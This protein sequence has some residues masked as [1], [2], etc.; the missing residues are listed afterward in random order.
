MHPGAAL[1]YKSGGMSGDRKARL[2]LVDD[3]RLM[4]EHL[5]QVVSEVG[6]EALVAPNWSEALRLFREEKP[7]LVLL[8]VIMPTM[9]GFKLTRMIKA[10][11]TSFVPV[12]LLTAL[13][14]VESKRRA[15]A[16]GADDFLSKPVT[17]LEL[18]IRVSSLLRIKQLTDALQEANAK[19]AQL[20]VTDPLTGLQNRRSLYEHL[21]REF[22]RKKR[23]ERPF[24][25][26]LLD[27]D[28]FK[29]V[30]DTHGHQMGDRVLRLVADVLRSQIRAADV[31]GRFGGEEFMILAPETGKD[32]AFA[33]AERIRRT[34]QKAS[35]AAGEG[36][37]TVTI[38][39]GAGCTDGVQAATVE[40]LVRLTDEALYRAKREGRNRTVHA[41]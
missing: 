35:A 1:W 25:L 28:H 19:L 12:I 37:P 7:D 13:E 8:D 29:S 21:D 38:S 6:H 22:C 23:Y 41:G 30:N 33:L 15:M 27:I 39:I 4:L 5:S 40:D 16:M 24:S 11:A 14:D 3:D 20:A 2:L 10:D 9:D 31:A 26:L 17:P 36:V 34:V 18:Q 32:A